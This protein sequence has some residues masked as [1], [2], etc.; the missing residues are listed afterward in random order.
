MAKR[1]LKL[2]FCIMNVFSNELHTFIMQIL[3]S[4]LAH[5]IRNKRGGHL[6]TFMMRIVDSRFASLH[7]EYA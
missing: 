7:H 3:G 6:A 5:H 2:T 4:I 1:I